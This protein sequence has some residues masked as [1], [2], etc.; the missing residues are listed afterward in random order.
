MCTRCQR[1]LSLVPFSSNS[2]WP[3]VSR[4]QFVLT[5]PVELPDDAHLDTSRDAPVHSSDDS[6][7]DVPDDEPDDE[8]PEPFADS[9]FK[10]AVMFFLYA[11]TPG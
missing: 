11:S 10:I 2:R 5:R 1:P 7:G 3:F 6:D 9:A 4:A 8:P